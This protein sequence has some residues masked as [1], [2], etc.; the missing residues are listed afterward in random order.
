VCI[1]RERDVSHD[2]P[3]ERLA[4]LAGDAFLDT[5]Q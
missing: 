3:E 1:E 2:L 4:A 5:A